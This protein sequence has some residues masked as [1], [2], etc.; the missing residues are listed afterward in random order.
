MRAASNRGYTVFFKDYFR[1]QGVE[2]QSSLI[3][4]DPKK[5]GLG[6]P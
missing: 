3:G 2:V 5:N 6:P 4:S 1:D